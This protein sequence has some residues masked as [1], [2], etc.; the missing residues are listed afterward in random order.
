MSPF[1]LQPFSET[2]DFHPL[3]ITGGIARSNHRLNLRY[4]LKGDLANVIIPPPNRPG[5]PSPIGDTGL[6]APSSLRKFDLWEAT[7][8]EFFLGV[9][10]DPGYWEFNLAPSGDWNSYRLDGYRQGLREELAFATLPFQV[11]HTADRLSLEL[12]L[13]LSPILRSDAL[14]ELSITTVVQHVD[15]TF[16][17]CALTH[18]GPEA[19]FHQRD[20]FI[21]KL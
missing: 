11:E 5:Y 18:C 9:K 8:F 7:C 2:P 15:G 6:A 21:L 16:S 13:D 17:Y 10:G 20:S 1:S 14:L 12:S 4:A 3:E 19:D